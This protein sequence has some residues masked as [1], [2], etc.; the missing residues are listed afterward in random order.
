MRK[1]LLNLAHNAVQQR[2]SAPVL[3]QLFP[4]EVEE[5]AEAEALVPSLVRA[6]GVSDLPEYGTLEEPLLVSHLAKESRS[7]EELTS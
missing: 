5:L 1:R 6:I 7:G 3:S 2:E 4:A